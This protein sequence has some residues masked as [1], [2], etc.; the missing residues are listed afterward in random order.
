M[1]MKDRLASFTVAVHNKPEPLISNP[2]VLCD[3]VCNLVKPAD[4]FIVFIFKVK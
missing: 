2:P 4:Q 3:P 1:D